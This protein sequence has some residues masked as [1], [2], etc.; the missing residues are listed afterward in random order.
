MAISGASSAARN[1]AISDSRPTKRVSRAVLRRCW[2]VGRSIIV[3]RRFPPQ[4]VH[5]HRG[6]RDRRVRNG[7]RVERIDMDMLAGTVLLD[8][9]MG[10]ELG[11]RGVEISRLI[12][13]AQGLVD[14]PEEVRAIHTDYI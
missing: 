8:G 9:G 12:W 4:P 7:D 1:R 13:S 6:C 2:R 10:R 11:F 14:A 5:S 3:R